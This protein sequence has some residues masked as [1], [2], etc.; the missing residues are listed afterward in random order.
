MGRVIEP[1][2]SGCEPCLEYVIDGDGPASVV[3]FYRVGKP[4]IRQASAHC[5]TR[6]IELFGDLGDGEL[7][8]LRHDPNVIPCRRLGS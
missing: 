1:G 2:F 3:V 7:R 4:T 6:D 5:R 8:T